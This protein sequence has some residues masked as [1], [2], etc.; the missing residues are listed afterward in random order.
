MFKR[1]AQVR[2]GAEKE[3]IF[4]MIDIPYREIYPNAK[5]KEYMS[6]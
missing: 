3:R 6:K 4:L 2:I 5:P 1:V